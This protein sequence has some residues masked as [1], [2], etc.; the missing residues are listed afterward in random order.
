MPVSSNPISYTH[1]AIS[2]IISA[3][4]IAINAI[5]VIVGHVSGSSFDMLMTQNIL[6]IPTASY[7]TSKIK[8][9]GI[10]EE[11]QKE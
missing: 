1:I 11:T 5:A 6:I 8:M 2:A 7:F 3:A 9:N 4:E 10:S